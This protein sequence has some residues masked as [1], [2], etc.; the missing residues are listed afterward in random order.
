M[1]ARRRDLRHVLEEEEEVPFGADGLPTVSDPARK[2]RCRSSLEA[3]AREYFPESYYLPISPGQRAD[4]ETMQRVATEGGAYAFAAPRSDG[5][6]TRCETATLWAL[7]YG[8]RKCVP[9]VGAD[10]GAAREI[11]ESIKYELRTNEALRADFPVPCWLAALSEDIAL[12]AKGWTWGGAKMEAEWGKNKIVL[13][14]VAGADGSGG[15][16]VCRGITGRL[17]GMRIKIGKRPVR[18][19][20]FVIDDPQTDESAASDQQCATREKII[21]GA[22]MGSKGAKTTIA[23]M[24]P[25]TILRSG[26]LAA[27]FLDHK[28]HPDWHGRTRSL[29]TEWPKEHGGLWREYR[30]LRREVS[31]EAAD[32]KYLAN[33]DAMDA[34]AVLDWPERFD[35]NEHSAIQSAENLLCDRGEEVFMAEYQNA[36]LSEQQRSVYDLKWEHVAKHYLPGRMRGE[37]APAAKMVVAATDI[38]L[39]GLHSVC[40]AFA[41]DLTGWVPWYGVTGGRDGGVIGQESEPETELKSKVFDALVRTGE[42]IAGLRLAGPDRKPEGVTAWWIDAGYMGDVVRRYI[43]GPG[44]VVGVQIRAARGFSAAKYRPF[45]VHLIG[46]PREQCHMSESPVV[47]RFIALCVDYWREVWQK[48]LLAEVDA[49]GS[50]SLFDPG[51]GSHHRNFAEQVTRERLAGKAPHSITGQMEW[52]WIT[53]PGRHDYGDCM[54]MAYAAAAWGGIGT[55]GQPERRA[56]PAARAVIYR[57]SQQRRKP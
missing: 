5:K 34:G 47:G 9:V 24:M 4:L 12:K 54:T 48:A 44:R 2:E 38:N 33:R 32:E 51:P 50:L 29:V 11:F 36:P 28:I 1:A 22:I 37:L 40:T 3:F 10:A 46:Q 57:P 6:T 43:D 26:D 19:D 30:R 45:G 53:Q 52:T 18:P 55:T 13:P 27:R 25:C 49:P 16:V 31:H 8:H 41:N 20:L 17:R 56:P 35:A 14:Q 39:Y 15:V 7:L 23:A 42:Q 21:L